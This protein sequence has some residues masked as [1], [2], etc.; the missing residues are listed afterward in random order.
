MTVKAAMEAHFTMS[1]TES[2]FHSVT[3]QV[4]RRDLAFIPYIH[5]V[6]RIHTSIHDAVTK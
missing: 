3:Q 6:A 2:P 4:P 1:E 5:K